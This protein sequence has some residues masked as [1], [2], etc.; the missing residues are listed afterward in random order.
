MTDNPPLTV[1]SLTKALP[2]MG[3]LRFGTER[4]EKRWKVDGP[5]A[6]EFLASDVLAELKAA[7]LATETADGWLTGEK[8]RLAE[9]LTVNRKH[10]IRITVYDAAERKRRDARDW[11]TE[12]F[13]Q[14]LTWDRRGI[15]RLAN[16]LRD[17]APDDDAFAA[18]LRELTARE[19]AT[20][21]A[22]A[23]SGAA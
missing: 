19:Q 15:Q 14:G 21:Q 22:I 20:T 7:K 9:R 5:N 16:L 18:L 23:I 10:D 17:A 11:L 4:I 6:W 3:A 13:R 8:F 1:D 2:G 12:L